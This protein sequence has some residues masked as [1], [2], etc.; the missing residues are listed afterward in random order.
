MIGECIEEAEALLA[1]CEDEYPDPGALADSLTGA[2]EQLKAVRDAL[3]RLE[4]AVGYCP[5]CGAEKGHWCDCFLAA[6]LGL[7][8][9]T[10]TPICPHL[11]RKPAHRV[12]RKC[13]QG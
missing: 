11:L 5:A 13:R 8:A 1:K 7:E 9:K 6:A 12:D 2:V 3:A 4:H 10:A